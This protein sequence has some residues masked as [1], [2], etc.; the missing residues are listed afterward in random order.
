[1]IRSIRDLVAPEDVGAALPHEHVLHNIGAMVATGGSNSADLEIRMED[2]VDYRGAPYAHGGRNMLMQKEDEAFRELERLQ[3]LGNSRSKPLVVD[4]TLPVEGRDVFVKERLNLAE[5]LQNL[6]LLTVTTFEV[7]R[8]NKEF[9]KGLSPK[10]Q[11]ERIAKTLEAE[12]MFGIETGGVVAFPGAIY[13]QIH[14]NGGLDAKHRILAEGLGL[15]QA[16]THAPLYLSFSFDME[17]E[18]GIVQAVLEWIHALLDAGAKSNK[19][20][21]CHVDRWCQGKFDLMSLLDLGVTV[22]F[23]MVGLAAVSD[24]ML[25]NPCH[26]KMISSDEFLGICYQE[27]SPDSQLVSYIA[28]LLKTKTYLQQIL[29]STNVHQRI[30]Y[31]RYGGGG[32]IYLFEKFKRR[33]LRQGVTEVEWDQIVRGNAVNL[34][35]WFVAPDA[36]PI[37]KN[38]LQCSIC[39]NYFEPIEGEYFT[40]FT[41]TYCGTKCLRRHS[42]QKFAPLTDKK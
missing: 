16:Q 34:L 4:V 30:Q 20:V 2:L 6:N 36:P 29:L 23:D 11:R 35:A 32:Y 18:D 25:I 40:K 37:P 24:V 10:E 15:A 7:E 26:S 1:M 12:L 9:T 27:P 39:G 21:V 13:Q 3:Q 33:L 5:R 19:L 31:R 22:L 41:F 42:R 14:A 28:N 17:S 38:Y 8:I